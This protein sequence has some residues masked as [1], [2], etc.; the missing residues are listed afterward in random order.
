MICN[1]RKT[2]WRRPGW[3][4]LLAALVAAPGTRAEWGRY[5]PFDPARPP[6][7][8]PVK[9]LRLE[10]HHDAAT[11]RIDFDFCHP[12]SSSPALHIDWTEGPAR[13]NLLTVGSEPRFSTAVE[14]S[15]VCD[16]E[17]AEADLNGD[18]FPDYIVVTHSGGNG[19]AG[20]YT[21]VTF[22]LSSPDGYVARTVFSFDA[23]PTDV[24]DLDGDGRPEFVHGLFVY[25]DPG[26]DGRTHNYWVYNLLG[27]SGTKLVSANR[28][29]RDFPRWVMY[30]YAPNHRDSVQLTAE[31]RER[32]WLLAWQ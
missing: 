32:Q 4:V 9:V 1:G 3:L 20:Q 24:V 30:S 23:A 31:Q 7:R 25:G 26:A 6:K 17:A 10:R 15:A 11:T 2:S 13:P 21:Y 18:F 19:L 8:F 27:F 5:S 28:S 14:G 22:L 29:S 12:G 16:A